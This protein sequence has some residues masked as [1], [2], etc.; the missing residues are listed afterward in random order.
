MLTSNR[1]NFYHP[2]KKLFLFKDNKISYND[3][4]EKNAI[5]SIGA[6]VENV[7][8]K[9]EELGYSVSH[10]LIPLAS[11][12]NLLTIFCF[13]KN[14]IKQ[15]NA[16]SLSAYIYSRHTNHRKSGNAGHIK[17]AYIKEMVEITDRVEGASLHFAITENEI[18]SVAQI[19][20]SI[21]RIRLLN[22][23]AHQDYFKNEI[24]WHTTES[25]REGIDVKTMEMLPAVETAFEVISDPKVAALLNEWG[26]ELLLK[27]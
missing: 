22:P 3:P 26:K 1:G 2:E 4:N 9:A 16:D 27:K 21:E 19:A 10:K 8:L 15:N 5:V 20:G 13:Q 25:P 23:V 17:P 11:E 6:C 24:R 18:K 7:I 14:K 12:K